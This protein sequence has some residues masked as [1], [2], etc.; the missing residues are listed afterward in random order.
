M[1]WRALLLC[2]WASAAAAQ[3]KVPAPEFLVKATFEERLARVFSEAC[4]G[5]EFDHASYD[6]HFLAILGKM[7]DRGVRSRPWPYAS[8]PDER[9]EPY[10]QGFVEKYD[11]GLESTESEMCAAAA[12]E[13]EWRTPLGQLL[14]K[15]G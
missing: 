9:F 13:H 4:P 8:I 12:A 5:F 11:F 6:R 7:S 15:A 2:L 10:V 3:T 1:I 14:R